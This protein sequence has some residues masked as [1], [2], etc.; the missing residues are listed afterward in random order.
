MGRL[1]IENNLLALLVIKRIVKC[2]PIT[3]TR[4]FIQF[5]F[6]TSYVNMSPNNGFTSSLNFFELLPSDSNK[7]RQFNLDRVIYTCFRFGQDIETKEIF[8]QQD[9]HW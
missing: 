8:S 2:N 6:N 9:L 1:Q 3:I 5:H 7:F 4:T